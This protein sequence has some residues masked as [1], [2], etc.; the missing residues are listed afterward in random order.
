MID[1]MDRPAPSRAF[2]PE[3]AGRLGTGTTTPGWDLA[4]EQRIDD[5]EL[6]ANGIGWFSIALGA[7]EIAAPGRLSRW[8]GMEGSENLL[9]LYGL[10]EIGKGVGILSNRRPTGWLWARIAGDF[11]DIATLAPGLRADNPKRGN[12][13]T[14]LAAVAGVTVLDVLCARQLSEDRI[15][16]GRS[17]G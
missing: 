6:L 13:V 11:L 7:A 4:T 9:R 10:R 14:A 5:G 1:T 8:L 2:R 3:M 16:P 17:D 12:V 15:Q